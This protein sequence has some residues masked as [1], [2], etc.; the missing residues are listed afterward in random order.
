[1][2]LNG[3]FRL[4]VLLSLTLLVSGLIA[5]QSIEIDS[6]KQQLRSTNEGDTVDLLNRLSKVHSGS[7]WQKSQRYANLALDL[8]TSLYDK[9][10]MAIAHT[11]LTNYYN[12]IQDYRNA[13]DH[14][15]LALSE[16]ELLSDVRNIAITLRI[17]G[18]TYSSLNQTDQSLDYYLRSLMIFEDLHAEEELARTVLAIGDVYSQWGQTEKARR[19]YERALVINEKIKDYH[20]VLTSENRLAQTL[21]TLHRYDQAKE[22]LERAVRIAD[23]H[24]SQKLLA[25]LYT[26]L[27]ELYYHQF[28]LNAAQKYF[29]DALEMKQKSGSQGEIALALS[30]VGKIYQEAGD[31]PEALRYYEDGQQIAEAAGEASVSAEIWLQ[32]GE[33]QARAGYRRKAIQAMLSGL[34]IAQNVNDLLTVKHANLLLTETYA[35][36]GRL[37]KALQY[38]KALLLTND[39]LNHQQN[40]R[41]TAELEVRYELDKRENELDEFKASALIKELEFKRQF[42]DMWIVLAFTIVLMLIVI[43]FI[44]YRSRL[45]RQA[46][47]EKM[48][49]ILRIKADFIAMLVHDLRSPLT[50]VFGFAELLK[51]GEKPYDRI[52]EIAITIRETSQKMLQLVN[53]MLDLSKFEAGKMVLSKAKIPLKTIVVSSMQMLQPVASQ[54]ETTLKMDIKDGLPLCYCDGRKIEQVITNFVSNAIQHTPRGANILVEMHKH[55]KGNLGYLY[56]SV[57]DDGPGVELNQ[58]KLIF[59]KYAQFESGKSKESIGTGLGLAVSRMIIEQHGGEVGYH[60]GETGGSVFYFQL[61]CIEPES[62]QA[63]SAEAIS[64]E[65]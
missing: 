65:A 17:I 42:T 5:E 32:I 22:H 53:E 6:L 62:S 58:Q 31:A 18:S 7:E 29:L 55:Q 13:L 10:G 49:H 63:S 44:F 9:Y 8:S 59:D 50:S 36:F 38:Q 57:T 25:E 41:R 19:F 2:I 15:T 35:Q 46:E 60:D 39:R 16:F 40:N 12:H 26:S 43:A 23:E 64:V 21:M 4:I 3:L 20:G 45:I 27:G 51:M 11:N 33:L 54:R 56:F 14:A 1:M 28:Q 52:R 34:N 30:D 47:Q 24:L 48:E 61:P 37:D